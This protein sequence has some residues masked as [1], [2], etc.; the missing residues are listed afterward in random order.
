MRYY[1]I[2]VY[3]VTILILFYHS[4]LS[5]SSIPISFF[6]FPP[7]IN[8][9]TKTSAFHTW[10]IKNVK[11]LKNEKEQLLKNDLNIQMK[12]NLSPRDGFALK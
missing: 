8:T 11:N 5:Y 1:F 2:H 7:E 6:F 3:N 10:L 9:R 12:Q 4:I